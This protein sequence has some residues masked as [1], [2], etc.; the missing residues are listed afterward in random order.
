MSMEKNETS[1]K[2]VIVF[3]YIFWHGHHFSYPLWHEIYN[4]WQ[5][6]LLNIF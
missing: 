2:K 5:E 6:L 1:D 4:V 3:S